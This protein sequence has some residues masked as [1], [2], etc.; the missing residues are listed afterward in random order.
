MSGFR[1]GRCSAVRRYSDQANFRLVKYFRTHTILTPYM[2]PLIISIV[3]FYVE[4][5]KEIIESEY[6]NEDKE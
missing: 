3:V 6:E 4:M 1:A 2:T 5:V